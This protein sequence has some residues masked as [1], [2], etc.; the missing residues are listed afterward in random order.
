MTDTPDRMRLDKWLWAARFFKTRSIASEA[1]QSGKVRL[2]D[3]RIKPA[4]EIRVGDAIHIRSGE[5]SWLVTV[6]ALSGRRGP[7][8]QAAL[9]YQE[10]AV[11]RATRMK[12]QADRKLA[13]H[14]AAGGTGRP[15]KKQRRQIVKFTSGE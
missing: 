12:A 8:P 2:E 14:P 7:A 15:T 6:L 10:D 11:S 13:P 1:V 9:L 5:T 3:E 4:K